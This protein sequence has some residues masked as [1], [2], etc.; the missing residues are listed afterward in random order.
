MPNSDDLPEALRD[1]HYRNASQVRNDPDFSVDIERL[2]NQIKARVRPAPRLSG[3]WIIG[4]AALLVVVAAAVLI[5]L[6]SRP[7]QV[8]M[9]PTAAAASASNTPAPPTPTLVPYK[10]TVVPSLGVVVRQSPDASSSRVATLPMNAPLQV[11][12]QSPDGAWLQ[13][14]LDNGE[15]DW[16]KIMDVFTPTPNI[17]ATQ[18][19]IGE[20]V[21]AQS[22]LGWQVY[23][24]KPTGGPSTDSF[25]GID[26]RLADAIDRTHHTL[27]IAAME[28]NNP[29]L[30]QAVLDAKGRGVAVRVVT[31]GELGLQADDSTLPQWVAAGIPVVGDNR[32]GIMLNH[33]MILDGDTV[34]LGSWSYT[35][36][37]TY[38]NNANALVYRSPD[39]AADF[40]AEFNEMFEQQQFG[41][42]SP[43]NT[44]HPQFVENGVPI[45]VYFTPEDDAISAIIQALS[46]AKKSIKFMAFAYTL[47]DFS[48]A[49]QARM[50]AGVAVQGIFET[51]IS[52]TSYSEF[53]HLFC[54]GANVR[55]DG[56]PYLMHHA[57]IVIDDS[58]IITG[59]LNFTNNSFES[60][61]GNV[62]II[63][64]PNL[65][66]QYIA[67]FDRLWAETQPP[68]I[69]C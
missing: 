46:A 26:N 67:E 55:Q 32:S 59:A 11:I 4:G 36:S 24:T 39:L 62:V 47:D 51:T 5:A 40:Q 57:T 33:F 41:P 22:D 14:R 45:Q 31:D 34:W 20:G 37:G 9:T 21:G 30:T 48:N 54:I 6:A 53:S 49:L 38:R 44:P 58:T 18:V 25:S 66:A 12:G 8:D 29:I 64:E 69:T 35:E 17:Q 13:V 52:N 42:R 15:T 68:E 60:N 65:A 19:H 63:Q 1:L 23:F 10:M 27:D 7:P 16:V 3:R 61:D 28:F 43:A 50:D 2:N 56:N